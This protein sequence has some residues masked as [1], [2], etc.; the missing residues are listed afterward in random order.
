MHKC[1]FTSKRNLEGKISVQR[2]HDSNGDV[3]F[4]LYSRISDHE[5][6]PPLLS[7]FSKSSQVGTDTNNSALTSIALRSVAE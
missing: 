4:L 3:A 2:E 6:S 5:H 7:E 1:L